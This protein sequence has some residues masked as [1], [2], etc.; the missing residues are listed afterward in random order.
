MWNN[1]DAL[2]LLSKLLIGMVVIAVLYAVSLQLIRPPFFPIKEINIKVVRGETKNLALQSVTN[3]QIEQLVKNEIDGNFISVNL[4]AVREAFVKLPWVREAKVN[5]EWPH[6]LNVTLEEHRAFA[7]WGS[8][9]LVNT[10]GEVFR[11]SADMDLPVFTGPNEASA[12]EVTRQYQRFNQ[13]LAPLQQKISEL[14]LTPRYAWRIQLDT[15]TILELGRNETEERLTRYVS[16]FN[17]SIAW[18]NQQEPLAYVDLRYPNGFA[19]R[20]PDTAP[21]APRKSGTRRET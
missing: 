16:V 3:E 10:Y 21:H 12:Q 15:G 5:R 1:P 7:Y 4:T 13:I 14:S 18:L 20:M 6:G 11:V 8:Q 9:A 17:H 2:N 19:I